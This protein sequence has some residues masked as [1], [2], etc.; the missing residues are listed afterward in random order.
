MLNLVELAAGDD[1]QQPSPCRY[2]NIVTGHACY[3]HNDAPEMPRKCP[4]WSQFSGD[5]AYWKRGHWN[6]GGCPEFEPTRK[7]EYKDEC[8]D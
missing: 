5:A 4:L 7:E 6:A 2:G 1:E 8:T 3:C